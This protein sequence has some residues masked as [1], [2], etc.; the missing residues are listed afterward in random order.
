MVK[1]RS[2]KNR[3]QHKFKLVAQSLQVTEKSIVKAYT[4]HEVFMC[5]KYYFKDVNK[6]I[7]FEQM[8]KIDKDSHFSKT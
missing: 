3:E 2:N 7:H 6:L 4:S 8:M 5:F 1:V